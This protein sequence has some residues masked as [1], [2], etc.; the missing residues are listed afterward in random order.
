MRKKSQKGSITVESSLI[1]PIV[2]FCIIAVLYFLI[3]LYQQV[4]SLSVSDNAAER[5]AASW[6]N[7]RKDVETGR[8]GIN[9][10]G[11]DGL[12]WRL[13]DGKSSLKQDKILNYIG[14]P[15]QSTSLL[16]KRSI[17]S[18]ISQEGKI[19][20]SNYVIYKNISVSIIKNSKIPVSGVTGGFGIVNGYKTSSF[21]AQPI[22]DPVE[23]IRN[24]DFAADIE[25]ELERK[26]PGLANLVQ[27]TG[28]IITTI[29]DKIQEFLN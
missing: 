11:K 18:N 16:N 20:F 5:G 12:Y 9:D 24:L 8:L 1:I 22:N 3:L 7:S 25:K 14:K 10:V 4:Y 27:K 15:G 29:K 6:S 17:L 21:S 23:L 2:I 26:N 19:N 13:F 28:E